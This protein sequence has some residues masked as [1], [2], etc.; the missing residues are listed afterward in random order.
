M[1]IQIFGVVDLSNIVVRE[2]DYG[3]KFRPLLEC[4]QVLAAI[5]RYGD[6]R[7]FMGCQDDYVFFS[8]TA[9]SLMSN[10][11]RFMKMRVEVNEIAHLPIDVCSFERAGRIV[12]DRFEDAMLRGLKL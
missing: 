8:K 1:L 7:Y 6:H 12:N 4:F 5:N 3:G 2:Y 9:R 11:A 10:T